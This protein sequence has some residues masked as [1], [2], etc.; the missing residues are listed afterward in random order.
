MTEC[1]THIQTARR[2][3]RG[4]GRPGTIEIVRALGCCVLWCLSATAFADGVAERVTKGEELAKQGKWTEAIENFKAADKVQKRAKHACLIALAYIRRELWPQAEVFLTVCHERSSASEPIPDWV[5]LAEQQLKDRLAKA[6]VASVQILVK[7]EGLASQIA[8]SSFEPDELFAPRAIHLPRGKHLITATVEGRE[9]AQQT[10]E[11]VDDSPREVVIDFDVK[12][13]P[14]PAAPTKLVTK[15]PSKVPLI[16]TSIGGAIVFGGAGYHLFAFRSTRDKLATAS[17]NGDQVA[18]DELSG[19][20]NS[21]R[22]TTIALY[23]VGAA[24]VVT[25]MVL[26]YTLY[27][28]QPERAPRVGAGVT[29]GGGMVVMEW[30]R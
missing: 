24:V 21:Q 23:S 17:T 19:K 8:V 25:G 5:P 30:N 13:A 16:V 29:R 27:K 20:F 3:A 15:R 1:D 4:R 12:Q 10:I 6:K 7:P 9:P 28:G 18:Y 2:G 26:R 22:A 14:I 11:I